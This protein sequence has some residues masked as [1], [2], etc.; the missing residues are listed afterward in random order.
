MEQ[1]E[2]EFYRVLN[3]WVEPAV[4]AGLFG[5]GPLTPAGLV[6]V[7]T[8]GRKSGMV[9]ATPLLAMRFGE[10]VVVATFRGERSHWARNM[11]AEPAVGYW[12]SGERNEGRATVVRA[13]GAGVDGGGGVEALAALLRPAAAFGWTLA[14]IVPCAVA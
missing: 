4:R 3:A 9:R 12:L 14:I 13:A 5:P 8:T 6:V 2:R 11:E 1:L 7:E 10:A